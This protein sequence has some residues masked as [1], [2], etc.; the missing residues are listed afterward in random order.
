MTPT[1]TTDCRVTPLPLGD[2]A[3][4]AWLALQRALEE[5]RTADALVASQ[6]WY[7]AIVFHARDVFHVDVGG[8]E[9]AIVVNAA[10]K[11]AFMDAWLS[12]PQ[13]VLVLEDGRFLLSAPVAE[14]LIAVAL[15]A[16][17]PEA[18]DLWRERASAALSTACRA[19]R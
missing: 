1:T 19:S 10:E 3:D 4:A 18:A 12:R 15:K 9:Q 2:A 14:T 5:D 17:D 8:S 16:R 11:R 13:P 6:Q 7:D